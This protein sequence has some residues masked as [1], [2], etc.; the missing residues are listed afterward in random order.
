[1]A[2]TGRLGAAR[3]AIFCRNDRQNTARIARSVHNVAFCRTF[4]SGR[5]CHELPIAMG[6]LPTALESAARLSTAWK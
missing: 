5:Y 1:M 3:R 6:L 2:E 4:E